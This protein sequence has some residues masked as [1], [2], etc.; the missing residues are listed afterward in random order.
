MGIQFS[1]RL[2]CTMMKVSDPIIFGHCIKVLFKDVFAKHAKTF[3]KLGVNANNGLC[4]IYKKIASLD[5][6]TKKTIEAD[7][8]ATYTKR[9]NV[10]MVNANKGIT[11]LHVP[12]DVIIDN[13]MPTAIRWGGRMQNIKGDDDFFL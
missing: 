7:I 4:D 10:A 6:A 12:S 1:L 11:N 5:D 3:E 9:G 8:A 13:S 2:K